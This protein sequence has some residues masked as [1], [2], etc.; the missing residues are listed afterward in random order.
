LKS[1]KRF[2]K[3]TGYWGEQAI[4]NS[5]KSWCGYAFESICYKHII[6]IMKK[7]ALKAS[8]LPYSWKYVPKKGDKEHGAQIDLLFDR[9]DRTITICEIKYTETPFVIDKQ[10]AEILIKK[11]E[12][13]KEKTKTTKQIFLAIISASGIKKSIYSEDMI[14]GIVTQEDL[15]KQE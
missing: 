4:G 1:I 9:E 7:L 6:Q 12:I 11:I 3:P 14:T 2:A 15:F 13:F 5:Y 8:A 10:Y